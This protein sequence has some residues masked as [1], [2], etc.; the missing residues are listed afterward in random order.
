MRWVALLLV[1]AC[2]AAVKPPK[3]AHAPKLKRERNVDAKIM[4]PR[5]VLPTRQEV[6]TKGAY[7]ASTKPTMKAF[8]FTPPT[9]WLMW[10]IAPDAGLEW[11]RNPP[12]DGVTGYRVFRGSQTRKYDYTNDVGNVIV[13]HVPLVAGTNFAAAT[14]YRMEPSP[15]V[16]EP[17][18][19]NESEFSQE[20][21]TT[22][23]RLKISR[24]NTPPP[25]APS[26][27]FV[28]QSKST[29]TQPWADFAT[30]TN[31]GSLALPTSTTRF[32]R[33]GRKP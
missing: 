13:T 5:I 26:G 2:I 27:V 11:D 14:A 25:V 30:V 17:D 29:L 9:L 32:F 7:A 3:G 6:V 28:I 24:T 33:V 10:W 19:R 31:Q 16:G 18:M 1:F 22:P 20:V 12:D 21:W 8:M 4:P 15:V 23:I